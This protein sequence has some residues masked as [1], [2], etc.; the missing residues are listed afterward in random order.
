V[1]DKDRPASQSSTVI[2]DIVR[3]R[4]GFDGWLMSDDFGMEAL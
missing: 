1:W 2:G 4:I 3:G